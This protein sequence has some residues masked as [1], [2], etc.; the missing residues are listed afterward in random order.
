LHCQEVVGLLA[1]SFQHVGLLSNLQNLTISLDPFVLL[2]L[3]FLI[4]PFVMVS[5]KLLAALAAMSLA[6]GSEAGVCRP[7]T[8]TALSITTSD[9]VP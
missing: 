3:V 8:T 5:R 9:D 4:K 2:I 6:A 1:V 7:G